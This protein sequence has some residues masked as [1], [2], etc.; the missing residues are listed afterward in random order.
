MMIVS[1]IGTRVNFFSNTA[2]IVN[3]IAPNSYY[4]ML[5]GTNTNYILTSPTHP[6]IAI[7]NHIIQNGRRIAEK[8]LR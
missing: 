5:R 1:H 4:G 3:C 6:I 2:A 8:V 7:S